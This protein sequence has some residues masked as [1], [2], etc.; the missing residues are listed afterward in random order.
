MYFADFQ[1]NFPQK[2]SINII[3]RRNLYTYKYKKYVFT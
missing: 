1:T 3:I 2:C